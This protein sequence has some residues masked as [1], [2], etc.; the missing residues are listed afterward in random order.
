MLM[1]NLSYEALTDRPLENPVGRVLEMHRVPQITL[2]AFCETPELI[3][4]M[5]NAIA[6]RRMSR[7]HAKLLS[8]GIRAAIDLYRE[9]GSPN[10]VILEHRAEVTDLYAQ[11]D[12]LADVCL[13]GT[14]V[15]VLGNTNDVAIYRELLSRGISEYIVSPVDPISVIAGISRLYQDPA[16]KKFGRSLAF[17]GA[18]GGVGSSTIAQNVAATLART[19]DCDVILADLDLPFGTASLG[20]DLT[21]GPSIAQALK[22]GSRLDDALLER[23]LIKCEAHLQILTAPAVLQQCCDFEENAFERVLDVAQ[24]NASFVVLDVPHIWT[25]WTKKTLISADEVVITAIPELASLRNAK[26]LIDLL[27]EARPNDAPPK[28]VL[29]QVG[30]PKRSEIKP[31]K[32]AAALAVEPIACI[33]FEASTVS[34]AANRGKMIADVAARS[35]VAK[36]FAKI[37]QTISGRRLTRR[38]GRFALSRFWTR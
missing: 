9:A 24:S 29:N 2:H 7:A 19:Y 20:F 22:D 28:L 4:M 18:N 5:E 3:H 37:S 8:G 11:L 6:D 15:I 12:A 36:S 25:S 27:K 31:D 23:L 16:G 35:P 1:T 10:L 17:I 32:F 21:T 30:M 13:A 33:P 34:A 14:K 26:N 38:N